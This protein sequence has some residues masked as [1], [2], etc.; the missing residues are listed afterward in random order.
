[1]AA[2]LIALA[3]VKD[4]EKLK[5]YAAGA[6]PTIAAYGGEPIVRGAVKTVLAGEHD[7]DIVFVAKFDSVED[8][9]A[10]YNSP[11]YQKMIPARSQ[12]L[13]PTFVVIEEL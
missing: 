11:E 7:G 9:K 2:Y 13:D 12:A 1:M 8:T 10:W 5:E 3:K 4:P 6:S